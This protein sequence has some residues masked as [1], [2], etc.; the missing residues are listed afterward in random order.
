MIIAKYNNSSST[1]VCAITG[2][3]FYLKKGLAFYLEGDFKKPV[4]PG[5]ALQIGFSMDKEL[6]DFV[7]SELRQLNGVDLNKL[8]KG[9]F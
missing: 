1:E 4:T 6:Y 2:D 7:S 5:V 8:I 3:P 9:T